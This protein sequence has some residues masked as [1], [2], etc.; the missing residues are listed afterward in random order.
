MTSSTETN[1]SNQKEFS[2]NK[3]KLV[4]GII[5]IVSIVV[6]ALFVLYLLIPLV[7]IYV[8]DYTVAEVIAIITL[9]LTLTKCVWSIS[10]NILRNCNAAKKSI[11]LK[12]E[13]NNGY[14]VITCRIS[15]RDARRIKPKDIYLFVEQGKNPDCDD[16]VARFPFLL[17]H[18]GNNKDCELGAIC[19]LPNRLKEFPEH[20]IK[21]DEYKGYE[22]TVVRLNELCQEGRHYIDPG[23][24]FSEDVTIKFKKTGVYRATVIWTSEKD[25]CICASKE[26]VV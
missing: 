15:N 9:I 8:S 12:I 17:C 4:V 3:K 5:A 18:E 1:F 10:K 25:D 7:Q 20:I 21:D 22:R 2:P 14:T 19:K 16:E 6:L 24:E 11:A 23:E 26:F 13:S